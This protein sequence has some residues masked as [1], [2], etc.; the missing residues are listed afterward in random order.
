M[1][2]IRLH[3]KHFPIKTGFPIGKMTKNDFLKLIYLITFCPKSQPLRKK[4]F[5]I[6][7]KR[8]ID[9]T[10]IVS[11]NIRALEEEPKLLSCEVFFIFLI[12][13][14]HR[15]MNTLE[16]IKKLEYLVAFQT[17]CLAKGDWDSF[18]KTENEIKKIEEAIVLKQEK[19]APNTA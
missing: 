6:D 14:P 8:I 7:K 19:N 2:I 1:L 12:F 9:Y 11:K 5:L 16:Q 17:D 3:S 10:I 13:V 18:D 15:A 4:A